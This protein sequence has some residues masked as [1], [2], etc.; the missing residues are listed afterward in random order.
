MSTAPR[1]FLLR[2]LEGRTTVVWWPSGSSCEEFIQR[3]LNLSQGQ[4]GEGEVVV[5]LADGRRVCDV[6][7]PDSGSTLHVTLPLKGG[8]GGF[9]K[10]IRDMG[11]GY[12]T[13]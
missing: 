1:Q 2:T 4:Y 5:R 7:V 10:A 8:K 9:G 13:L 11:R 6:C 12:V 3:Q